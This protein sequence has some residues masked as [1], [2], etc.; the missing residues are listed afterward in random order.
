[1]LWGGDSWDTVRIGSRGPFYLGSPWVFLFSSLKVLYP[2]NLPSPG[3]TRMVGHP[4]RVWESPQYVFWLDV[5]REEVE[6]TF[7]WFTTRVGLPRFDSSKPC[8]VKAL[9][10]RVLCK[11]ANPGKVWAHNYRAWIYVAYRFL[12]QILI[13]SFF[14]FSLGSGGR[15]GWGLPLGPQNRGPLGWSCDWWEPWNTV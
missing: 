14:F 2:T 8:T 12:S 6:R 9:L 10:E 11:A 5:R 15:W 7:K 13:W 3:Q 4:R 1:M